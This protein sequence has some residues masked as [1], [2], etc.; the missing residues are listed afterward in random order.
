M[1]FGPAPLFP[2]DGTGMIVGVCCADAVTAA[3]VAAH[4]NRQN[5]LQ[6][7]L[8]GIL[9]YFEWKGQECLSP[10]LN[11]VVSSSSHF[12]GDFRASISMV[13]FQLELN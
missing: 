11:R 4:A 6:V 2:V 12:G 10:D 3:T 8:M 9:Q 1:P 5:K 13:R 7:N